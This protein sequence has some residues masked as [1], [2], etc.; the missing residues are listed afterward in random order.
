MAQISDSTVPH[1]LG[2]KLTMQAVLLI[3]PVQLI[4]RV[5]AMLEGQ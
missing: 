3:I 5:L 2:N 4:E 1:L